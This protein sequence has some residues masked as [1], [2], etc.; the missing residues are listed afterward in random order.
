MNQLRV[1]YTYENK[2]EKT[3]NTPHIINIIYDL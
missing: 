1:S 2:N 3:M